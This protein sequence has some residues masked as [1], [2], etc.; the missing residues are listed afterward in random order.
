MVHVATASVTEWVE[1]AEA[2]MGGV[3]PEGRFLVISGSAP[4]LLAAPATIDDGPI[5]AKTRIR[6]NESSCQI[7]Y[8][9]I[10]VEDCTSG[11]LS[12]IAA[13]EIGHALGV[14]HNSDFR[15]SM[16]SNLATDRPIDYH[17]TAGDIEVAKRGSL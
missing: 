14:G 11:L 3:P 9:V 10:Y 1:F 6:W 17:L 13:H 4:S 8:G 2:F 15:S 7:G 16:H 12:V 5:K